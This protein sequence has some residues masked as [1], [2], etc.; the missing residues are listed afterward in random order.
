MPVDMTS[1]SMIIP[2]VTKMPFWAKYLMSLYL[3]DFD[4][5]IGGELADRCDRIVIELVAPFAAGA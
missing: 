1:P 2:G 3:H 4:A 5:D